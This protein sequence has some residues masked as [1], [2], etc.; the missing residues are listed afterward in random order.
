MVKEEGT[1]VAALV[2]VA[3]GDPPA[4]GVGFS[5]YLRTILFYLSSKKKSPRK[6]G[7]S[8]S[9]KIRGAKL[10]LRRF[11]FSR[12]RLGVLP[13]ETLHPASSIH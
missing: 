9:A 4:P 3:A 1:G 11:H 13:A 8:K 12:F 2:C 10:L 7:A 5:Q 6:A